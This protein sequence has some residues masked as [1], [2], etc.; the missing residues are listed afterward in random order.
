MKKVFILFFL[1][2]GACSKTIP[3]IGG[4]VGDLDPV[5]GDSGSET[6]GG[7]ETTGDT[8][9]GS[10]GGTSSGGESTGSSSGS[11]GTDLCAGVDENHFVQ[12]AA[13]G[14][15]QIIVGQEQG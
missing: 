14:R 11:D 12:A 6:T 13:Q 7:T 9:G 15:K 4:S 10:V 3:D 8:T 2:F 5:G 1:I